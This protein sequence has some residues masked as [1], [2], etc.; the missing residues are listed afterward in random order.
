MG[1]TELSGPPPA[2]QADL[3]S[4]LDLADLPGVREIQASA[5]SLRIAYPD[6]DF[7]I[8]LAYRTPRSSFSTDWEVTV[9]EASPGLGTWSG[10]W[11]RTFATN[12]TDLGPLIT[13][14]IRETASHIRRMLDDHALNEA[15][16]LS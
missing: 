8:K 9:R 10:R 7:V 4:L 16:H 14:E 12:H 6:T 13:E 3:S 2:G 5:D 11:Q 1:T 15:G